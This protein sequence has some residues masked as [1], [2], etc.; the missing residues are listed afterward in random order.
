MK[1]INVHKKVLLSS[2]LFLG[3]SALVVLNF[4]YGTDTIGAEE[5]GDRER[6]EQKR[7]TEITSKHKA[8]LKEIINTANIMKSKQHDRLVLEERAGCVDK[9]EYLASG[10]IQKI[11]GWYSSWGVPIDSYALD[12]SVSRNEHIYFLSENDSLTGLAESG[13][14][15]ANY[16]LGLNK[17][18][19]ALT[20]NKASSPKL[21]SQPSKFDEA[22]FLEQP[23]LRL[24]KEGRIFLLKSVA[25]GNLYA[26]IEL[27][28]SYAYEYSVVSKYLNNDEKDSYK[29]K[30]ALYG[31]MPNFLMG[32]LRTNYFQA[33]YLGKKGAQ[34]EMNQLWKDEANERAT[35][36]ARNGYAPLSVKRKSDFYKE[37]VICK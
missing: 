37:E 19:E 20:G 23:N 28:L 4:N 6:L 30:I 25:G 9:D 2:V 18:W 16:A 10:E 24:M 35:Y 31:K 17:V 21:S 26:Y 12:G 13:N 22:I 27:A 7:T 15:D 5:K 14:R 29:R 1:K 32:E 3:F 8:E 36:R 11:E 34:E 33:S